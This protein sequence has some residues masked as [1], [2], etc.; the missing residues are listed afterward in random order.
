MEVWCD[1][2][3]RLY[4]RALLSLQVKWVSHHS[5]LST[6][7][8]AL[9]KLIINIRLNVCSRSSTAALTLV[10]EQGKVGLLHSI[11]H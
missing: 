1:A 5:A 7:Y 4:L 3:S 6:L 11:F 10:E 8:T 9:N 2:F